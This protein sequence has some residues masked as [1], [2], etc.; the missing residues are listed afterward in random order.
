MPERRRVAGVLLAAGTSSRMGTNKLLVELDGESVIRRAVRQACDANLDPVI[1]VLGYQAD[2]VAATV[3]D[4]D[5]MP[6]VNERYHDGINTSVQLG[7]THVPN[8]CD[9]A[10]VLL[11][12]MPRVTTS[13]IDAL[14]DRYVAGRQ[15]EQLIISLYGEVH[16][17]PTLYDRSLFSEFDGQKG[18]G[19]GRR[20]VLAH[21][22]S[23]IKMPWSPQ[24]IADL[25]RP[26]DV[27]D[28]QRSTLNVQH[29]TSTSNAERPTFNNTRSGGC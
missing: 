9:A 1:V 22:E 21:W 7:I 12:D 29:P 2:L 16:A 10:V 13:M 8:Q 15:R 20:I 18:E 14:V 26:E 4:L 3:K 23:A 24:L 6:V 17:P 11:A 27:I 19:C 25:D 28:V 5:V